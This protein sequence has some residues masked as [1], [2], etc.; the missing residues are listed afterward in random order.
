MICANHHYESVLSVIGYS[1]GS[2]ANYEL[3]KQCLAFNINSFISK[4]DS[5]SCCIRDGLNVFLGSCSI[6]IIITCFPRHSYWNCLSPSN[7]DTTLAVR[8]TLVYN[9][10]TPIPWEDEL[11]SYMGRVNMWIPNTKRKTCPFQLSN[12]TC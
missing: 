9:W 3:H 12:A 10:G 6:L 1:L 7:F 2:C 8:C 5:A 11:D 4:T